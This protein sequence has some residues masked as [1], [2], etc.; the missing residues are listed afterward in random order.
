MVGVGLG[1][2]ELEGANGI[3]DDV[4][5]FEQD[6]A[7][8]RRGA[9]REAKARQE[10]E[11]DDA[12]RPK[13]ECRRD[14]DRALTGVPPGLDG[15]DSSSQRGG[16]P[17]QAARSALAV[18]AAGGRRIAVGTWGRARGRNPEDRPAFGA[19]RR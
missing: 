5:F 18:G 9:E 17:G 11:G 8:G 12:F 14:G 1:V 7:V 6:L 13:G 15:V 3:R 19:G 4:R 10:G 2:F 16:L